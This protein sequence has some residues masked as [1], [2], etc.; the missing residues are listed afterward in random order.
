MVLRDLEG[1]HLMSRALLK[2]DDPLAVAR[3]L[4]RE[5]NAQE[6][7]NRRLDYPNLGIV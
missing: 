6:S 3:A 5:A 1:R 7:F 2:A 4:L